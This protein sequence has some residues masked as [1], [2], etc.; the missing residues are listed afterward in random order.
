MYSFLL[1]RRGECPLEA[2]HIGRSCDEARTG[3]DFRKRNGHV[4]WQ[5]RAR[6]QLVSQKE[7]STGGIRCRYEVTILF[8]L[9]DGGRLI[10]WLL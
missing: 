8:L 1:L 3:G 2:V 10:N 7:R 5:V 4:E 6:G 9:K